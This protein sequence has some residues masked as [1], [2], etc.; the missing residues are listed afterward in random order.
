MEKSVTLA[1]HDYKDSRGTGTTAKYGVKQQYEALLKKHAIEYTKLM[2]DFEDWKAAGNEKNEEFEAKERG[3]KKTLEEIFSFVKEL[4]GKASASGQKIENNAEEVTSKRTKHL[5]RTDAWIQRKEWKVQEFEEQP[6]PD[7]KSDE[8]EEKEGRKPGKRKIRIW[9]IKRKV[10]RR[11]FAGI[12][13]K[14][15]VARDGVNSVKKEKKKKNKF[16]LGGN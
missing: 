15:A 7:C 16:K 13:G 9:L 11:R 8:K 5:C 10:G 2:K 1:D 4:T 12:Q 14:E 3:W 6:F